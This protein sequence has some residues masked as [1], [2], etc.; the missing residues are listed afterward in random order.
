[1]TSATTTQ[2]I[3]CMY[4]SLQ[5]EAGVEWPPACSGGGELTAIQNPV[6]VGRRSEAV[7][8]RTKFVRVGSRLHHIRRDNDHQ[9]A[10]PTLEVVGFEQGAE[11]RHFPD[12]G[13][14]IG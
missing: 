5:D 7:D 6:Q 4:P 9:L 13:Q 14:G 1:M 10:L 12:P 3:W 2:P 8:R 11:H